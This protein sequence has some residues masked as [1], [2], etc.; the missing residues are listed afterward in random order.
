MHDDGI[1]AFH[2]TEFR[3]WFRQFQMSIDNKK[4]IFSRTYRDLTRYRDYLLYSTASDLRLQFSG[5]YLGVIWWILDPLLLILVYVLLVS[6]IFKRGGPDYPAFLATG[7]M[8]WKWTATSISTSAQSVSGKSAVLMQ[9]Y[10]P[11]FLL[12]V[13]KVL[14]G[15]GNFLVGMLVVLGLNIVYGAPVG[16]HLLEIIPVIIAHAIFLLCIGLIFAHIGVF[17]R[18]I[19]NVLGFALKMVFFLSP[20]LY[21]L[22]RVP[23]RARALWW[24]NPMTTFITSYRLI[25]MEG[26]S[27]LYLGLAAWVLVSLLIGYVGLQLM[28][29]YDR[30]YTKVV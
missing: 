5:K 19:Q 4:S 27:P 25:L 3:I 1:V 10:V 7:L 20:V 14:V 9:V 12:P 6:V 13:Q 29:R 8:P 11:K 28:A 16:F 26:K 22:D 17:F 18:D 30:S 15:A 21:A 2:Q 24:L 23:E